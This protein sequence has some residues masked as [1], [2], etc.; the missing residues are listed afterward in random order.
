MVSRDGYYP[1]QRLSH[2]RSSVTTQSKMEIDER[3]GTGEQEIDEGLYSRQL[4][5]MGRDA[6]KRMSSAKVL[7]CGMNGL[8]AEIGKRFSL[9]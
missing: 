2:S 8:G 6:Q 3:N 4:Y 5:V 7:I 9:A 1:Q